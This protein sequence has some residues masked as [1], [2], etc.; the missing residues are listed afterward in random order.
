MSRIFKNVFDY[1]VIVLGDK[2][3]KKVERD[4]EIEISGV[5]AEE[6]DERTRS[7]HG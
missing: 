7:V 4:K 2:E 3:K 5:R 1:L 6:R